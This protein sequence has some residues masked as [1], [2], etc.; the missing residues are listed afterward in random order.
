MPDAASD[1]MLLPEKP[2]LCRRGFLAVVVSMTIVLVGL[3]R[4]GSSSPALNNKV[5]SNLRILGIRGRARGEVEGTIPRDPQRSTVVVYQEPSRFRYVWRK[6]SAKYARLSLVFH[7]RPGGSLIS[8][9]L[10]V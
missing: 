7:L 6:Q 5:M 8:S 3:S 9:L 10:S 1:P 2:T 4:G